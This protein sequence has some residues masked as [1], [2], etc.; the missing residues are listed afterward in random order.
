MARAGG[1][2]RRGRS[3]R[4]RYYDR[5]GRQI[6]DPAGLERI[7]ALRVPPAWKDVWISPRPNAKLQ[8]VGLDAAG[9]RQYLY[10]PEYRAR[11]EQAKYDKLIR[12]A[13]RLPELR[14]AMAEHMECDEL[15]FERV[16]AIALR[17]INLGWFRVGS[18]RYAK[19][20]RTFGITTLRKR[21]V[22]VR[23]S[24]ITFRFRAKHGLQ[25]HSA[26]VDAEVAT[27]IRELLALGGGTRL[28]RYERDGELLPLTSRKLNEYIRR[29]MGEEFTAKDFRTWGGT[30][31]AAIAF[32]ERGLAETAGEQKRAVAAVM[33]KVGERLGNTPAVARSSYVSPAVVEQYLDG[34]TIDDFRPRHLRVVGARDIGLDVEEQALLSL[35]RSWRIRA[36]RKAA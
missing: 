35:L 7:E 13:E 11:Q 3:G 12:V 16:A 5:T 6:T 2:T 19:E 14:Q 32:A 28:F 31:V 1:I 27:T 25:V 22:T 36:A 29:Y 20:S 8:A 17:L 34:R 18:E 10:H 21:H 9:R 26:I 4:F 30:L 24:R 33:R 23:G 15:A